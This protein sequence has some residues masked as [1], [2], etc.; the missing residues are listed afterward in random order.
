MVRVQSRESIQRPLTVAE[1]MFA[2][3]ITSRVNTECWL[4][5]SQ[6]LE[7]ISSKTQALG[8]KEL[9]NKQASE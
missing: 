7:V 1:Q 8:L 5:S 9:V 4:E 6:E 2:C 3:K